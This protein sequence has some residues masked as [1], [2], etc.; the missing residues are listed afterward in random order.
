MDLWI[1]DLNGAMGES[2]A[3]STNDSLLLDSGQS[4]C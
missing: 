4:R 1:V 2:Q 3:I